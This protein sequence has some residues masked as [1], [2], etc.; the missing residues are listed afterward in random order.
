MALTG[1]YVRH[2]DDHLK[3]R[4]IKQF[5]DVTPLTFW[6]SR[7]SNQLMMAT[8]PGPRGWPGDRKSR[9]EEGEK[10]GVKENY[11]DR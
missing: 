4:F 1:F 10:N 2:V 5:L 3:Q 9:N 6:I 8:A 11:Q 7:V